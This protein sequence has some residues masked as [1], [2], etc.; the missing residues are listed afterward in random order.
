LVTGANRGI[1]LEVCRQLAQRG[2]TA[3]LGSRA[4]E[5][6]ERAAREL[7]G[8]V[9]ACQLDVCD[10]GSVRSAAAWL[11]RESGRLD[12]LVNNPRSS[13]TPGSA[14]STPISSRSAPRSRPTCSA[15]GA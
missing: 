1:G 12:V 15:P 2:Y 6:G 10:P 8:D 13:T 14:A 4:L 7:D 5:K 11:D 9:R 3:V